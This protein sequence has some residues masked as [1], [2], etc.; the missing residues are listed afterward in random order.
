[1]YSDNKINTPCRYTYDCIQT[2]IMEP[3]KENG[4][5]IYISD[6]M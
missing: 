6:G 1:M 3:Y 2:I 4:V 5:K